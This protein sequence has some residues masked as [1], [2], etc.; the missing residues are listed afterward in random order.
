MY[1]NIYTHLYIKALSTTGVL[2]FK[3]QNGMLQRSYK[4]LRRDAAPSKCRRAQQVCR[5]QYMKQH[6]TQLPLIS[7]KQDTPWKLDLPIR[8]FFAAGY[9][10]HHS[11]SLTHSTSKK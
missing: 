2:E 3:M 5:C 10:E 9:L 4:K 6:H 1:I 11:T 8:F 7:P